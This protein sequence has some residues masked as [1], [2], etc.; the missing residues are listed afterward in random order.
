MDDEPHLLAGLRRSLHGHRPTW[1]T[2]F[3]GSG[4]EALEMIDAGGIDAVVSDMR[5]PGM[6]GAR[7]LT[8]VQRRSPG[9]ARIVLSGQAD[10]DAV[11]AV[12]RSAQKF[13]AKPCEVNVLV[14]A[15][16]RTLEVQRQLT[17]PYLRA[18]IGGIESVPSLPVVYH[19]L[20]S[21]MN[22]A[23][24]GLDRIAEIISR[25]IAATTDLLKLVNSA[26]FGLPRTVVTVRTAV[27]LLG[28]DNIQALILTGHVFRVSADL[29]SHLDVRAL[30][31]RALARAGIARAVAHA[32]GWP[33]YE[34]DI[35]ALACLLRDV[36]RLVLTEG[37]PEQADALAAVLAERSPVT[38]PDMAAL[39]REHFGCTVAQASA[40]LLGLWAFAPSVV[41]AVANLPLPAGSSPTPA[42]EV[43]DFSSRYVPDAHVIW[44]DPPPD[45]V[46]AARFRHW[47]EIARALPVMEVTA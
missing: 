24:T 47:D 19:E 13:L 40:Y 33:A 3:A 7:L 22:A 23:D 17:D 4:P 15:V 8:E 12:V 44:P 14:E 39:E 18:L 30:Q 10:I 9:T 2:R 21:A 27:S 26:F 36:G 43:M 38:P 42:E 31:S 20:V 32:E 28:L 16:E 6:D 46:T 34:C 5:M 11:L 29:S 25:D 41:H 1:Q 45:Q 35:V 37:L